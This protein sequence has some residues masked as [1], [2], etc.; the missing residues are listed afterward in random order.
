MCNQI[1]MCVSTHDDIIIITNQYIFYIVS[2][3]DENVDPDVLSSIQGYL[4][5]AIKSRETVNN[6]TNDKSK[7]PVRTFI[8]MIQI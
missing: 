8:S 2:I 6:N 1:D 4:E 3:S 5:H 7:P